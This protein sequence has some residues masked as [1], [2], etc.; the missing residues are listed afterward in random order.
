MSELKVNNNEEKKESE[1]CYCSKKVNSLEKAVKMLKLEIDE[2]RH[3]I[4]IIKKA[5][6]RG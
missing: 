4:E 1:K 6:K 2:Q 5:L 3:Q